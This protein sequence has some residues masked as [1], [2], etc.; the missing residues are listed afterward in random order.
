MLKALSRYARLKKIPLDDVLSACTEAVQEV[1]ARA[2]EFDK[3]SPAQFLAICQSVKAKYNS[4]I[5]SEF[6][7]MAMECITG[8]EFN[9]D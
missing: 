5:V 1:D 7:S 9:G 3:V 8:K 2:G 6:L 4:P